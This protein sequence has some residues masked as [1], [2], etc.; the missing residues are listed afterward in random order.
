M[1][2]M[3]REPTFVLIGRYGVDGAGSVVTLVRDDRRRTPPRNPH[4]LDAAHVE[5]QPECEHD[6]FVRPFNRPFV[7]GL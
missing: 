1:R 5:S 3:L 4:V 2:E 7:E 6:T